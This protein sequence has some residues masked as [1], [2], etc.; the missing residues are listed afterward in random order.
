MPA[1]LGEAPGGGEGGRLSGGP[2][3]RPS[4]S[5]AVGLDGVVDRADGFYGVDGTGGVD[6]TDGVDGL[7]SGRQHEEARVLI[8]CNAKGA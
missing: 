4:G 1:A 7:H 6:G 5:A 8:S 2:K 3:G